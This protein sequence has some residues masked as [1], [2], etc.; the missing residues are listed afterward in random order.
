M[1]KAIRIHQHGGPEVL[2]WEDV[3]AGTPGV[4]EVLLR[5]TAIG[6]NFSDV[7]LRTGQFP[8]ALP[9]GMGG[10]GAGIVTA[11]GPRVK[12]LRVGDRVVYMFPVPGAYCEQRVMPAAALLKVPK[13]VSDEQAAAV[14][15]KGLTSWYLL[16]ET[17]RVKRGDSV[18][19]Q[20]A[21]GGMGLILCQWARALGARVMGVVG[22]NAKAALAARH[23]CHHVLVGIED[24]GARVR[25]INKG[26]GVDVVYDG[27][28]LDTFYASLDSLRARGLMVSFG[29]ASGPVPP[30]AP[31]E[32]AK[33]GSLYLTRAGG[34]DYL[35]DADARR[36]G[37]RELFALMK[38]KKLRVH[39]G[40]RYPLVDAAQAQA[41]L[42]ARRT[43]GSTVLVP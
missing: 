30:F 7:Y 29:N 19:I 17:Y 8:R 39:I 16:R 28:G 4:G 26:S 42:E 23:G 2:Q 41:D 1:S 6:L 10:E 32:L 14:L 11:T 40:Q 31:A 15:L 24:L 3:D 5:H 36:R 35:A 21:S 38:K 33:R 18:L 34:A 37:V 9:S 25:K 13:G 20:A 43:I 27:T 22:S 12:G